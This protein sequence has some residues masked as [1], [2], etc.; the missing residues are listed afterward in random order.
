LKITPS[1]PKT[2]KLNLTAY[3]DSY[4]AGDKDNRHSVSG[5][6]IFLNGAV[7]LWKSK[8]QKPLALSSAEAE[9]YAMCEAAK[10]VKYISMVLR[11]FGIEVEF[12]ITMYCDNV[13]AIFMTE[14]ASATSRTKHVDA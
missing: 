1:I 6:S 2:K 5:Y 9:Y 14:N 3:T 8:L 10:D 4:W 11:Y 7:I 12:P 13:G